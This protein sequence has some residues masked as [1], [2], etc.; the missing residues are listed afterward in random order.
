MSD[1][2]A[3]RPSVNASGM[4]MATPL[5][6]PRP[7]SA[8]MMVPRKQP[9]SA[10]RRFCQVIAMAKPSARDE[11]VSMGSSDQKPNGPRASDRP[12]TR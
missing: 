5:D 9:S 6:G 7:G 11:S 12:R 10:S 4:R 3:P 8:P 1:G 2:V